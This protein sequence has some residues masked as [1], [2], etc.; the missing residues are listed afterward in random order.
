MSILRVEGVR[1]EIGDFVILDSVSASLARGER[2]G[3]VGPNGAGKT[4]LLQ[5]VAGREDRTGVG[6]PRD[7]AAS[8]CS[9]R[10]RTR[11]ARSGRARPAHAVRARG[12][13]P[14]GHGAELASSSTAD[15]SGRGRATWRCASGSRCSTATRSTSAST[16]RSLGWASRGTMGGPAAELSGGEQTRARWRGSSSP[17]RTCCSSTS[18]RTTSTS[19]PSSGSRRTLAAARAPLVASH[20]RAF[21]DTS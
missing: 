20:D 14:R 15:R 10:K 17:I 2:V 16:R 12:G 11:P 5:I 4:T 3:L 9:P 6:A 19:A 13:A 21:L 18:P 1:R 7:A 8:G